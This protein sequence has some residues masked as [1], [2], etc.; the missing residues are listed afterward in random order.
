MFEAWMK[1]T[2]KEA[3]LALV[4]GIG[5]P[6]AGFGSAYLMTGCTTASSTTPPT[7]LAP[8]YN[9]I[10]DQTVGQTLAAM[11]ALVQ[12]ATQDYANLTPAQQASEKTVLNNFVTAVN[13]A[14]SLYIAYHA[15]SGTLLSAQ[16]AI[17]DAQTAQAAYTAVGVS[18]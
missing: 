9:N 12:K 8:G 17:T 7:A 5:A 1:L 6:L 2:R 14:D 16:N 15:G 11:H 13:T 3:I 10:T 4:L 18:K